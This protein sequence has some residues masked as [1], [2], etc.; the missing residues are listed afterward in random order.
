MAHFSIY[1]FTLPNELD[2]SHPPPAIGIKITS[3]LA[4]PWNRMGF[5]LGLAV[6]QGPPIVTSLPPLELWGW[7]GHPN[8]GR[9]KE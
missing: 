4:A 7:Q 1:I 9:G 6:P 2:P 5:T 3:Q 8:S